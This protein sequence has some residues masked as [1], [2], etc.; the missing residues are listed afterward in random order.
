MNATLKAAIAFRETT[1]KQLA[2]SVRM[3]EPTL[4]R[5]LSDP[6]S[7]TLAEFRRMSTAL[8]LTE[9]ERKEILK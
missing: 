7:M 5:K 1:V 2:R 4:Y 8:N 9:E 3:T 6:D